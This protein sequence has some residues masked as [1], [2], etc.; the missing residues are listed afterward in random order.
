MEIGAVGTLN[1]VPDLQGKKK[2][3]ELLHCTFSTYILQTYNAILRVKAS[4]EGPHQLLELTL[5][6]FGSG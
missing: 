4:P 3:D 6:V 1:I 2:G 5:T